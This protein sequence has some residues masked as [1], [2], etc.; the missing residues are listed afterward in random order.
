MSASAESVTINIVNPL[1]P[2]LGTVYS[3]ALSYSF[4]GSGIQDLYYAGVFNTQIV[5][6]QNQTSATAHTYCIDLYHDFGGPPTSWSATSGNSWNAGGQWTDPTNPGQYDIGGALAYLVNTYDPNVTN[7][8]ANNDLATAK[9][10]AA[11]LQIA[12]WSVDYNGTG[13]ATDDLANLSAGRFY[14][15]AGNTVTPDIQNQVYMLANQ[16]IASIGTNVGDANFYAAD[17]SVASQ[18]LIGPSSINFP[19][20]VPEP[21]SIAMMAVGLWIVAIRSHKSIRARRGA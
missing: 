17:H 4:N 8:V 1:G 19:A 18:D 11:A 20:S 7:A 5:N 16:E 13:V 10:Q 9:L 2:G 21:S 14:F 6:S 3:N 12:I 15:R